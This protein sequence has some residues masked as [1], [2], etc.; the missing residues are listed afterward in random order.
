MQSTYH[1]NHRPLLLTILTALFICFHSRSLHYQLV[2][3]LVT[4]EGGGVL[5]LAILGPS[6]K[7]VSTA[8]VA[9]IREEDQEDQ[10]DQET[11]RPKDPIHSLSTQ[12]L[13]ALCNGRS[14]HGLGPSRRPFTS[15]CC[16]CCCC[17]WCYRRG[18][19]PRI[20]I[21]HSSRNTPTPF[22]T[23]AIVSAFCD[24]AIHACF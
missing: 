23:I 8:S 20:L 14:L 3:C 15:F 19:L 2:P 13:S 17:C 22:S 6:R 10:E 12:I 16:C 24:P 9:T 1:H 18:I 11:K 5:F 7:E 4:D 21:H